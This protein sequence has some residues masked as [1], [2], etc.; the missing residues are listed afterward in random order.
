MP[1]L[2]ALFL[3]LGISAIDG[4]PTRKAHGIRTIYW[5]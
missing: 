4:T 1:V 5:W 2:V 3:V